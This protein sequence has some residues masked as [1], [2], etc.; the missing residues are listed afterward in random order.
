MGFVLPYSQ[1]SQPH[2][3]GLVKRTQYPVIIYIPIGY[4]ELLACSL[5]SS[6]STLW[7]LS[8]LCNTQVV[9][10]WTAPYQ[11]LPTSLAHTATQSCT[12]PLSISKVWRMW[13]KHI[14]EVKTSR[15]SGPMMLSWTKSGVLWRWRRWRCWRIDRYGA[16][17]GLT[18]LKQGKTFQ[19]KSTKEEQD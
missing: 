12:G 1:L 16:E 19:G 11:S 5:F 14:E 2:Q 6:R 15:K 8:L 10:A 7:C 17:R 9:L 18:N 3:D 4:Q 13:S